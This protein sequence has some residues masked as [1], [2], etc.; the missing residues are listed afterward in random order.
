MKNDSFSPTFRQQTVRVDVTLPDYNERISILNAITRKMSFKSLEEKTKTIESIA[1]NAE[2]KTGAE[3]LQIVEET[4]LNN[5]LN[6]PDNSNEFTFDDFISNFS[7]DLEKLSI[8]HNESTQKV[9]VE[10]IPKPKELDEDSS[11]SYDEEKYHRRH[12]KRRRSYDR[13]RNRNKKTKSR[14]LQKAPR[15]K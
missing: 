15:G 4:S 3:L 8:L 9:I 10:E 11:Y 1:K 14:T 5:L 2:G 7:I 12:K 6:I 13:R